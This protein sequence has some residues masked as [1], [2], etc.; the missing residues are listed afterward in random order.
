MST[1]LVKT[2]IVS[3]GLFNL[4]ACE[5]GFEESVPQHVEVDSEVQSLQGR[6]VRG[7][8]L[9]FDEFPFVES[10]G[11]AC[12]TCHVADD[13]FQLTP[14]HVEARWQALQAKKRRHPHAYADD[15]LFRSIDADDYVRDFTLLREHALVR[16]VIPLPTDE[17]GRK[18]IWPLDDPDTDNISVF[19]ATPTIQNVA[20]NAPYQYDGRF[21]TLQEQAEAALHAHAEIQPEVHPKLLNDIAA[22]ERTQ[23]SSQG[24]ATLSHAL[25]RGWPAPHIEPS[26]SAVEQRGKV[27]LGRACAI[28][29]G[30]PRQNQ[31]LAE[32]EAIPGL[33]DIGISKP[34]PQFAEGLPL[35]A[36]PVQSKQRW[37]AIR[38]EGQS[39]PEER[40][41]TDPG[42]IFQTGK[43]EHFN[44]FDI[45]SLYGVSQTAPYFRDNSAA[46]LE[47]VVRHYQLLAEGLRKVV[48]PEVPFPTRPDAILDSDFEP[49]IAYLETL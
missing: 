17:H 45:P 25:D 8:A 15:P 16:V 49:L 23:F 37:W 39:E 18:L 35:A 19:R 10:N 36:S 11:R 20:I 22:F 6:P 34:V 14:A 31:P 46:T 4:L 5:S 48:P 7:A 12:D 3:F 43:L 2:I 47:Q 24:V 27:I 9:F 28:C 32:L 41:S 42:R 1:R 30:G 21:A 40:L 29:H 44:E 38:V 13:A 26:L 33:R